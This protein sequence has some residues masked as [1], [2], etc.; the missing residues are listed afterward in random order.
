MKLLSSLVKFVKGSKANRQPAKPKSFRTRLALEQLEDRC[1]PSTLTELPV[2]PTA[3][4]APTGITTAYDGSVWFTE[5]SAN[6]VARLNPATGAVTE[7]SVPTAASAPDQITATPDGNVWFTERYGRNVGRINEAGGAIAEFAVPGTGAYPTTIATVGS[8]VW[9]AS[10]DSAATARLGTINSTGTITRLATGATRTT[11]TSITGGPDGNLWVT[12]VSSYWGDAVSEVVTTGFGSFTN[13]RLSNRSAG[14][15]SITVGSD[16]NLWFTEFNSDKIGRIPTSA[17][18]TN[19]Q[20]TE[21]ALAAG[22]KP[23]QIVSGPDGALWFTEKGNNK[24]GRITTTG[25]VT[26]LTIS[27]ASSQPFGITRGLDGRLWFTEESGDRLGEIV[28]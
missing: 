22:S 15:Q 21:F 6:K 12:E 27:T 14:P 16:G 28:V 9:F 24:I 5:N 26:E 20:I 7:F 25:V 4:A 2:L 10:A 18:P 11:I 8:A 1:M 23:Q 3:N 19:P 13:F 17:T